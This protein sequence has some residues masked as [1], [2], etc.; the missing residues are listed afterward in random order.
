MAMARTN[1]TNST[2]TASAHRSVSIK[3]KVLIVVACA[4]AINIVRVSEFLSSFGPASFSSLSDTHPSPSQSSQ[5]NGTID[6]TND[7][8]RN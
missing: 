5:N 6:I 8:N 2:N 4:A 3:V 7:Y 1:T